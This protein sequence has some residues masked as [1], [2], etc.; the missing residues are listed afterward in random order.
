M[1]RIGKQRQRTGYPASQR[2]DNGKQQ[3]K[4]ERGIEGIVSMMMVVVTF[5]P[6]VT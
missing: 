2:L 3:G 6:R 4:D 5:M 1:H